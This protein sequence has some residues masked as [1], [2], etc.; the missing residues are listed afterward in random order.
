MCVNEVKMRMCLIQG[1]YYPFPFLIKH[2]GT[3]FIEGLHKSRG[4]KVILVKVDRRTKFAHFMALFH[5]YTTNTVAT[6]FFK[7][8]HTLHGLPESIVSDRDSI[9][10][11]NFWQNLF[12]LLGTQLHY[13]SPSK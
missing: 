13:I 3:D 12:R 2:S 4:K 6:K 5:P 7:H 8:V 9:F 11:S 10:L 1:Y